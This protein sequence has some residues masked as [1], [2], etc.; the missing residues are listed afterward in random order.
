MA[1]DVPPPADRRVGGRRRSRAGGSFVIGRNQLAGQPPV[2]VAVIPFL[3]PGADSTDEYL[4]DGL[5]DGLATALGRVAGVRVVS[6]S[7]S[8][9]YKGQRQI[10]P[11]EVGGELAAG[12]VLQG[13][14]RR[15]GGRIYVVGAAHECE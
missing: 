9:R 4:A 13:S 15:A 5:A 1:A 6:R 3:N 14:V 7:L 11:R 2:S 8:Q 12:Q 10:D